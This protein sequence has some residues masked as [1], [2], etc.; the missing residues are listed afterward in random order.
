MFNRIRSQFS[1]SDTVGLTGGDF[2]QLISEV[3]DR[4]TMKVRVQEGFDSHL[5][6]PI[7]L[8]KLLERQLQFKQVRALLIFISTGCSIH[9]DV[10]V[11]RLESL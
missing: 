3:T 1:T 5:Q 9:I 11:D 8:D 7:G 6:D 4:I 10:M 2:K